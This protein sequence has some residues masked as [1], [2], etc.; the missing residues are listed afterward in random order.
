MILSLLETFT[1]ESDL[2]YITEE[3]LFQILSYHQV[4]PCYLNFITCFKSHTGTSDLRFG[5]FRCQKYFSDGSIGVE[6]LGRSGCRFQ[7]S[8]KLKTARLH[9]PHP[10]DKPGRTE[11]WSL[12]Q[13][14]V[15]HHF[16]VKNARAFW[17]LTAPN[18]SFDSTHGSNYL[19]SEISKS[20]DVRQVTSSQET[21][22]FK[23]SFDVLLC[24]GEWSLG[25]FT[26]YI[27]NIED[28]L[29]ELVGNCILTIYF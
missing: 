22:R 17:I 28:E 29:D 8:F 15:Y 24:L 13:A 5:G 10:K 25:E 14:A 27:Q 18:K 1:S 12:P 4:S 6:N 20:I 23:S 9:S 2:L 3:M 21:Q 16:D 26:F 7:L 11:K 19:W